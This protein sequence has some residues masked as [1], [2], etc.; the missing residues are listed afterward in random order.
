[1]PRVFIF[2]FV[3]LAFAANVRAQYIQ[4]FMGYS[5]A[6]GKV[7]LTWNIPSGPVSSGV[8]V[9]RSADSTF[10]SGFIQVYYYSGLC[11]PGFAQSFSCVDSTAPLHH[12]SYYRV[13]AQTGVYSNTIGVNVGELVDNY[14]VS[15]SPVVEVSKLEFK[16]P[17]SKAYVLEIAHPKGYMMY[18]FEGITTNYF[19]LNASWF[20]KTGMYFFRMYKPDGSGL[21]KGKFVVVRNP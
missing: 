13:Y 11:G 19:Y 5:D 14:T 17:E 16:N 21:I 8:E 7:M 9:Q 4:N 2:L 15:P 6:A 18:H 20:E 3:L 1:M 12:R 10:N